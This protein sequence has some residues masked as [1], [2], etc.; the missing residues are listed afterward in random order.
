MS[1][2]LSSR[3]IAVFINASD[4]NPIEI[5]VIGNWM[6]KNA[7]MKIV[8]TDQVVGSIRRSFFN[9]REIFGGQQTYQ[10]QVGW[11]SMPA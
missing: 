3:M 11:P 10:V 2:V 9:A 6:D 1:A 5:E 4:G 7:E 8:G